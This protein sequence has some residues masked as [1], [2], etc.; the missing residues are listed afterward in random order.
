VLIKANGE[1]LLTDFG[2]ARVALRTVSNRQ[3]SLD[4]ANEAASLCTVR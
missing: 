4:I 2:S 1:P 3:Q